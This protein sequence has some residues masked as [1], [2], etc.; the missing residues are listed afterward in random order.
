MGG[1][2]IADRSGERGEA[3]AAGDRGQRRQHGPAFHERL[4]GRADAADLDQMVDH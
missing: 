4:I 1:I 2:A 3:N